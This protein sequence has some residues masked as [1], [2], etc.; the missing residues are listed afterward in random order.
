[1]RETGYYWVRWGEGIAWAVFWFDHSSG[2]FWYSGN[3]FMESSLFFINETR[4]KTPDEE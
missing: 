1:M 3:A 2:L 4:I